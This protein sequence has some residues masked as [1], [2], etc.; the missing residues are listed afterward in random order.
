LITPITAPNPE[1]KVPDDVA[2]RAMVA[3][4]A[5]KLESRSVE[6]QLV[7]KELVGPT[8]R[9]YFFVATDKAPAS[10]EWKYL[11]QGMARIGGIALAFAVLTNDGQE[12]IAKAAI[13]MVRQAVYRPHDTLGQ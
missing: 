6:K 5:R 7:I 1:N 13:E 3:A 11:A 9:G 10:G 2:I 12:P 8:C 4:S